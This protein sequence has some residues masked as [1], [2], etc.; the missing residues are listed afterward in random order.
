MDAMI[1]LACTLAAIMMLGG[2]FTSTISVTDRL[3]ANEPKGYVEFYVAAPENARLDPSTGEL[4]RFALGG[5]SNRAEYLAQLDK[6]YLSFLEI[7]Q[8]VGPQGRVVGDKKRRIGEFRYRQPRRVAAVPG[9]NIFLIKTG[10]AIARVHVGVKEG[11]IVPVRIT[12]TVLSV[13]R[14]QIGSQI[15]VMQE[16]TMK[17]DVEDSVPLTEHNA[18]VSVR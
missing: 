7:Y 16:F 15:E 6:T 14:S 10:T 17:V 18:R 2:C 11:M 13:A 9:A 5:G 8:D 4:L 1:K 12:V 3:A